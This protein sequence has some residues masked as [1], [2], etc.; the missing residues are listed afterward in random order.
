MQPMSG[1][2]E[3]RCSRD[4]AL[5]L[6]A[7]QALTSVEHKRMKIEGYLVIRDEFAQPLFWRR[8]DGIVARALNITPRS[9]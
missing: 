9:S 5:R 2:L 3:L 7:V 6:G 1:V 4:L 8:A